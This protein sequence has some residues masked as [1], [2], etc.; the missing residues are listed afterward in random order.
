MPVCKIR[1][2]MGN[3]CSKDI[4]HV[5][6]TFMCLYEVS[7][8]DFHAS[9]TYF[10][11]YVKYE[12]ISC[13]WFSVVFLNSK[14][15]NVEIDIINFMTALLVIYFQLIPV[16]ISTTAHVGPVTIRSCKLHEKRQ[17]PTSNIYHFSL[18]MSEIYWLEIKWF[19]SSVWQSIDYPFLSKFS[20][21]S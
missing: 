17:K 8:I 2:V 1:K 21:K 15:Y 3:I 18:N 9:T 16:L 7:K 4:T 5:F 12:N 13:D 19:Y 20:S 6:K 10:I 11:I 14:I